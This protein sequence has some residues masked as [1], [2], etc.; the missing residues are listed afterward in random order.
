MKQQA[1]KLV[2]DQR[3]SR[4]IN[5][6]LRRNLVQDRQTTFKKT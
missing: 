6:S 3:L 1:S 4:Q 5:D 2:T